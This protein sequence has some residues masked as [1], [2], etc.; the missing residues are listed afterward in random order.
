MTKPLEPKTCEVDDEVTFECELSK[1]N[2]VVKWFKNGKPIKT[3]ANYKA[4]V[5]GNTYK[6]TIAK[7]NLD[8]TAEYSLKVDD[9]TTKAPLTVTGKLLKIFNNQRIFEIKIP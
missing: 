2:E 5:D 1:P 8:D 6:L 9:A 3:N 7:A 4:K